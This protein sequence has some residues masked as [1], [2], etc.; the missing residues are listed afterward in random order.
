MNT[1]CNCVGKSCTQDIYL[2]HDNLIS[3][4]DQIWLPWWVQ[5][6]LS[7]CV[8]VKL[9]THLR[10]C[11]GRICPNICPPC[12]LQNRFVISAHIWTPTELFILLQKVPTI[13][14][15]NICCK[16]CTCQAKRKSNQ[17]PFKLTSFLAFCWM[18][19]N[20]IVLMPKLFKKNICL[21]P[22]RQRSIKSHRSVNHILRTQYVCKAHLLNCLIFWD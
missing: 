21:C 6:I 11:K 2:T 1:L 4:F 20:Q 14:C 17:L 7:L 16:I 9:D 19:Y 15:E 8:A 18:I 5:A 22:P 13:H 3:T 12:V 10:C